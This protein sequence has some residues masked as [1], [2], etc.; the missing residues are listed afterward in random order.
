MGVQEFSICYGWRVCGRCYKTCSDLGH[1][2]ADTCVPLHTTFN[3]NGQYTNQHGILALWE[4]RVPESFLGDYDYYIGKVVYLWDPLDFSWG[5]IKE[6]F[7][8]VDSTLIL[9]RKLSAAYDEDRKYRLISKNGKISQHY[10][11]EFVFDYN[12]LLDGMVERRMKRAIFA[13]A[14]FWYSAWIDAGQPE[15]NQLKYV[16]EIK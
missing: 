8:L 3:Y 14:S 2:V 1:Y 12:I 4:S 10:S 15:L 5:L 13:T 6:S 7:A 16:G 11:T 9:E